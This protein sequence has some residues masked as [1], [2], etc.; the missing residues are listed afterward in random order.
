MIRRTALL[1]VVVACIVCVACGTR[2]G[3]AVG[4]GA[5]SP[6]ARHAVDGG[7][8]IADVGGSTVATAAVLAAT[9]VVAPAVVTGVVTLADAP[10]VATSWPGRTACRTA[11]APALARDLAGAVAGAIVWLELDGSPVPLA[12]ARAPAA[13]PPLLTLERCRFEPRALV[14]APGGVVVIETRDTIRHEVAVTYDDG[15]RVARFP[16]PLEGQSFGVTLPR[17]GFVAISCTLHAGER[18]AVAVLAHAH[19]AATGADGRF[20]FAAVPPGR[21]RARAQHAAS[22]GDVPF[23]AESAVEVAAAGEAELEL[24]LTPR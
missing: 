9:A 1:A 16:L 6:P 3:T 21:Y 12:A 8:P 23:V 14:V 7:G 10:A 4:A 15:E 13:P 20:S 22:V 19:V 5:D 17:A 2:S 11:S 18:A 24:A